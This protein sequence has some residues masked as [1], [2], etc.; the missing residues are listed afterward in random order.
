MTEQHHN[1]DK[2]EM[3]VMWIISAV[4]VLAIVGMV[5]CNMLTNPDWR[6]GYSSGTPAEGAK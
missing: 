6:Q 1:D 3:R 4:I 2:S 5:G